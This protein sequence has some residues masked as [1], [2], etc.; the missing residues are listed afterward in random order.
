MKKL[1]FIAFLTVFSI[2]N[3]SAQKSD[4]SVSK[5]FESYLNIK[6][7]LV[8]DNSDDA[9]KAADQFIKSAS[10]IDFKVISKANINELR[11]DALQI[12]ESRSIETQ[13]EKFGHLSENLSALRNKFKLDDKPVFV[14]YCPMANG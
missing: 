5:V 7:A 6:N 13:R 3:F 8:S 14:I 10:M 12:A 4:A 9:S 2:L 11:K 1:I